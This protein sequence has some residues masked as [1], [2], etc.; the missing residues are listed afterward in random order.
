[1][2]DPVK[3]IVPESSA[4]DQHDYSSSSSTDGDDFRQPT[5]DKSHLFGRQKPVHAALGGGKRT[6]ISILV[7]SSYIKSFYII[8]KLFI[9]TLS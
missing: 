4:K 6:K 1:M 7:G 2:S 5:N 8:F 9:F 3:E